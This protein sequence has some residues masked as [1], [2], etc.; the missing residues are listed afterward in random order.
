MKNNL[1]EFSMSIL[2]SQ[3][4]RKRPADLDNQKRK[5]QALSFRLMR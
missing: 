1:K 2:P 3:T 4:P 5:T